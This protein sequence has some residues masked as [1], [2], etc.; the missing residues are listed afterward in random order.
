MRWR[1]V[2]TGCSSTR[3]A[4]TPSHDAL[5]L[6]GDAGFTVCALTPAADADDI[7]A[8]E[9]TEKM[10]VVIGSERAGLS[11]AALAASAHRVRIPMVTGADSL[12]AAAAAAI[13]CYALGRR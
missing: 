9:V 13:A 3:R 4:P 6:L 8:I 2:G 10:A 12:N 11:D 7:G 1:S 5:R